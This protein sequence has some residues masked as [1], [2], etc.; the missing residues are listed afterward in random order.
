M[1]E[2]PLNTKNRSNTKKDSRNVQNLGE[3][4]MKNLNVSLK[5]YQEILNKKDENVDLSGVEKS[6][7]DELI[8]DEIMISICGA[9]KLKTGMKKLDLSYNLILGDQGILHLSEILKSNTSL[10]MIFLDHNSI[11]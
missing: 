6:N 3:D 10:N 4:G 2:N 9:L 7:E 11:G 1:E 8:N 5:L